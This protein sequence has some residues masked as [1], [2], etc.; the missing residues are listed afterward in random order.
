MRIDEFEVCVNVYNDDGSTDRLEEYNVR[1]DGGSRASAHI[2]STDGAV[3]GFKVDRDPSP[4][5]RE[6]LIRLLF[7]GEEANWMFFY[8]AKR[9]KEVE[10]VDFHVTKSQANRPRV[11]DVQAAS[12]LS[13]TVPSYKELQSEPIA[14]FTY[15]YASRDVLEACGIIQVDGATEAGDTSTG[16]ADEEHALRTENDELKRRLGRLEKQVN[17]L[18]R[19]RPDSRDDGADVID[20]TQ[21]DGDDDDN[22]D[23]GDN[24]DGRDG[25]DGAE[26]Q[27]AV[28]AGVDR[29]GPE[30]ERSEEA[31][32]SK[33]DER[34]EEASGSKEGGVDQQK[35]QSSEHAE[36]EPAAEQRPAAE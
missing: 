27:G 34:S 33:E 22:G 28:P 20:L 2:C 7:D 36:E 30:G 32:G 25:R 9:A 8:T 23:N 14:T 31:S 18:K 6:V 4:K 1:H 16:D 21:D 13:D 5:P 11:G 17:L 12:P 19:K 24:G 3:F 15:N 29:Q 26:Q 35:A 10:I